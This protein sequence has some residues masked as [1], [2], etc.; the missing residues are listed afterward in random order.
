MTT[1]EYLQQIHRLSE[2]IRCNRRRISEIESDISGLKAIDYSGDKVGGSSD[3]DQIAS[4]VARLVDLEQRVA[5]ETVELQ[6]KKDTIIKEIRSM[7]DTRYIT[8]LTM[9]YVECERWE[10][11]AVDMNLTI[12]WVY[13]MHG[14]ALKAFEDLKKSK[15]AC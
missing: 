10:R 14:S 5:G 11:I 3:P 8:L 12:R 9:R 6:E 1:K 4:K 7:S 2:E 13:Q 15:T